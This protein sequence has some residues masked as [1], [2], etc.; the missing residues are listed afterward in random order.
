MLMIRP[1]LDVN[2]GR[3]HRVHIVVF[4]MFLVA[5]VGGG[6][7]PLGDP[8]LFLGF[9]KGV[10]FLWTTKAM[11]APTLAVACT[12]LLAFYLIEKWLFLR[13][14]HP[15]AA[16]GAGKRLAIGGAR[17]FVLIAAILAFVLMSGIWKPGLEIEIHGAALELQNVVRDASLLGIAWISW[18]FT[19][20]RVRQANQFEWG[21]MRE[22]AKLFA[23]IFLTII[24]AVAMLRAG[25]QG[26]L[27]PLLALVSTEAGEPNNAAY[28]WLTGLLSSVLDNAPTYLVFFNL[29]GGDAQSLM[30]PMATTLA[31]ISAGAVFMGAMTYIGNAPNFMIKAI[32]ESRGIRMPSF[33][34]YVAWSAAILLPLFALLQFVFFAG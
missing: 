13:G 17:N 34:G 33:F 1:L 27:G 24:P 3:R 18:R 20:R 4:F 29:A 31:A 10:D 14:D 25:D 2:R 8:P 5:N 30:G 32:A 16:A 9:L 12:L 19:P 22:V 6:L 15:H 21:P 11:L 28:F 26:V 7:T 23:A